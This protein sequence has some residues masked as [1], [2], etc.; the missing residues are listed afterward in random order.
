M[1]YSCIGQTE[2]TIE[3]EG[4][5]L[6]MKKE[7]LSMNQSI[8][9]LFT[10]P[11]NHSYK[12]ASILHANVASHPRAKAHVVQNEDRR[13][14]YGYT[15]PDQ[16]V[17]EHDSIDEVSQ[18]YPT[19]KEYLIKNVIPFTLKSKKHIKNDRVL[20]NRVKQNSQPEL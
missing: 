5:A 9:N 15:A 8:N 3:H 11:A 19:L 1:S 12:F 4:Y 18:S 7:S 17:Q 14:D 13:V 16:Y 6:P 2:D 10:L 20:C